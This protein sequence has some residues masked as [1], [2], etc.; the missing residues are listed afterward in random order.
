MIGFILCAGLGERL[1][2]LTNDVPK[3]M[4]KVG[5]MPVLEHIVNHMHSHG[6]K[7]IMVNVH[8]KAEKIMEYFGD[9]LIYIHEPV[10]LGD[11]KTTKQ[12]VPLIN[13]H[14]VV[15]N[16]DTLTDI[17]I[18]QMVNDATRLNSSIASFDGMTYTGTTL[19]NKNNTQLTLMEY[20][21][22][23]R[24]IGT[25]ESLKIAQEEYEN[26]ARMSKLL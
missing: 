21:C 7:T 15:M 26:K 2:P 19:Y 3:P 23:W 5:G 18:G 10:L 17:N 6:I 1:K 8:Y 25:P 24:D 16:G 11:I 22:Y 4:I 13:N 14:L 12:I 20:G 9:K